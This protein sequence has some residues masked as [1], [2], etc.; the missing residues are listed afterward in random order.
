MVALHNKTKVQVGGVLSR[1]VVMEQI[2]H[3]GKAGK[4]NLDHEG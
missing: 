2:V 4:T 1:L 3:G